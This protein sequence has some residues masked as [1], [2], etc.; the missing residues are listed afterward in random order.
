[1]KGS[2]PLW[3]MQAQIFILGKQRNVEIWMRA[4]NLNPPTRTQYASYLRMLVDAKRRVDIVSNAYT[5]G[6]LSPEE[7]ERSRIS[8]TEII[9]RLD[10]TIQQR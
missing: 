8:I 1:M 4:P 7:L 9:D 2:M 3:I 10:S 5:K 6:N